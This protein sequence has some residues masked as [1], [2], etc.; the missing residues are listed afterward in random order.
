[1]FFSAHGMG[2]VS[3]EAPWLMPNAFPRY[4]AHHRDKPLEAGMVI[5]IETELHHTERG[6]IKLEDTV[7]ITRDRLRGLRRSRPRLEHRAQPRPLRIAMPGFA[8]S[9]HIGY[10][11]T[12]QPMAERVASAARCGFQAI[13]HP[14]PYAVPADGDGRVVEVSRGPLRPA[15]PLL[16]RRVEGREGARHLPRAA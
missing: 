7:A 14:A 16:G 13:E 3:H 10:L 1:M 5:S 12:E 2:I 15:G 9:A 4:V 8:Y 11:F 6:F